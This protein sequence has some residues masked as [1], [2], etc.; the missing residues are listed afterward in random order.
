MPSLGIERQRSAQRILLRSAHPAQRAADDGQAQGHGGRRRDA[1]V[2][3]ESSSGLLVPLSG[4][5]FANAE[6]SFAE[7]NGALK[8]RAESVPD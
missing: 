4:R 3:N 1:L 2:Q 5:T 8:K 7:L 6:S